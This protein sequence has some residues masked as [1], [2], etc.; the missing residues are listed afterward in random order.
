MAADW[1]QSLISFSVGTRVLPAPGAGPSSLLRLVETLRVQTQ[2]LYS[3][4]HL[5][6]LGMCRV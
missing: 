3:T 5:C 4:D 1:V 6:V 2:A